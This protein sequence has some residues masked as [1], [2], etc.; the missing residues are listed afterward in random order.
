LIPGRLRGV[1]LLAVLPGLLSLSGCSRAVEG[2][3][4]AAAVEPV[5]GAP[6]E[7]EPLIVDEV[8]SGLPRLPDAEL[9]PPAGAKRIEDVA[10]YSDDP[11]GD[12]E[13]LD[14]FGYR[15]GWERFWGEGQEATT[16]VFVDQ[17]ESRA[18]AEAYV[19]DLA[20]NDAEHYDGVLSRNPPDL[21]DGCWLLTVPDVPEEADLGG[22]AVFAACA[23]GLFSV[24]V[25]AVTDSVDAAEAEARSV[26]EEQLELLPPR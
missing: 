13:V 14:S 19:E 7:L 25:S 24:S 4:E 10:G 12:R 22:P 9:E 15:H 21:P 11:A 6:E 8:P 16:G 5:P 23:H 17:F 26:L 3:R 1:V 18:G 2:E 20:R